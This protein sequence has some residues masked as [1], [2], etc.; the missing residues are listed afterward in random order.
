MNLISILV[1]EDE[2]ILLDNL[3]KYMSMFCGTV[4][5][6]TNGKEALAIYKNK[7]PDIIM[8]DIDIPILTGIEFIEIVRQKDIN[9]KIIILSAYTDTTDLLKSIQLKL[10]NYLV[11]PIKMQEL[12]K[13]ITQAIGEIDDDKYLALNNDYIWNLS[14]NTLLFKNRNIK[15]TSYE[16]AFL[17]CLIARIN[18]NVSY[19]E[20]HSYIY[21]FDDYSQGAITSLV[22]RIRKK[23]TK[24]LIKS[25]FKFGYKVETNFS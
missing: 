25:C 6:A 23:T 17:E 2:P 8:T 12:K 9:C 4:Y 10:I 18:N 20:I 19:E 15:L 14:T 3:V 24:E 13:T 5:Q 22:K 16:E 1:V 11:K 21:A 7:Q